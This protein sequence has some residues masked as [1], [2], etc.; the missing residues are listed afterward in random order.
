M[1]SIGL[2]NMAPHNATAIIMGICHPQLC[3]TAVFAAA[4]V[5]VVLELLMDIVVCEGGTEVVLLGG[6]T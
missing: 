6:G 4:F 5:G 1:V 3:I 2:A